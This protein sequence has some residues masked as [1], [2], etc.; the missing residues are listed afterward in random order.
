MFKSICLS[1]IS[2][3]AS[4]S[5]ADPSAQTWPE[6]LRQETSQLMRMEM[7]QDCRTTSFDELPMLDCIYRTAGPDKRT[8]QVLL[9]D[10]PQAKWMDWIGNACARIGKANASCH[11]QVVQ[12]IRTQSGGQIPWS[13]IIYE[14]IKPK[15]GKNEAY[16]FR[17]G[18]SVAVTGLQR[19]LTRP[20]TAEEVRLCRESQEIIF[21][22]V[23]PRPISLSLND[24]SKA[25]GKSGFLA[26]PGV[27]NTKWLAEIRSVLKAS[28]KS[29]QNLFINEW[30]KKYVK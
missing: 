20:L 14:D 3:Y 6:S 8:A 23:F 16:C 12:Q 27:G 22:G 26:S 4:L 5:F 21:V 1:F 24:Y 15:D 29:D 11:R 10:V 18:V 19:W 25:T 2:V 7:K 9:V 30:A 17:T 13:G 28:M